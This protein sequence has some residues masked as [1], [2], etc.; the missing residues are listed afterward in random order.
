MVDIVSE[1]EWI[2]DILKSPDLVESNMPVM[3]TYN[4]W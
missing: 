3:I 2:Q 1:D 4:T